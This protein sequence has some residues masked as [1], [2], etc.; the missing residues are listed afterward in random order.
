MKIS[1]FGLG[2][3]GAVS[4][5]CLARDGHD[6]IGVDIDLDKLNLIREGRTPVV[7]EGMVDLMAS[8]TQSGRVLVTN[9][10]E[11]AIKGSDLS[12]ICVGTPS[13][14]NGSQDQGALIRV[15]RAIGA[16]LRTKPAHH[17]VAY[18]STVVP[19]TVDGTLSPILESESGKRPGEGFDVVFQPEFLRKVVQSAITT[20]RPLPSLVRAPSKL[21]IRSG[22]YSGI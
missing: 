5:G 9:D 18:R 3:V 1:I 7:E 15:T 17:L 10:V 14:A 6:V 21:R 8:A 22:H 13:A 19:G 2:Y 20:I 16:A 12:F 11:T 4:L